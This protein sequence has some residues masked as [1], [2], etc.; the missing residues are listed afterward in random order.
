MIL[1]T[2]AGDRETFSFD[3][4]PIP[5]HSLMHG[6]IS[7]SGRAVDGSSAAGLPAF[8]RAV[9]L[10]S[11][12]I[13]MLPLRTYQGEG[14]EKVETPAGVLRRPNDEMSAFAVWEYA[15]AS[16]VLSGNFFAMKV[17]V[18]GQ[19]KALYPLD[20]R[21]VA[22]KVDGGRI[23]FKVRKGKDT[24][25]YTRDD[26]LFIPGILLDSPVVGV[27]I[28]DNFRHSLGTYLDRQEFESRYLKNDAAVGVVLKHAGNVLPE[29]REEIRA[30]FESR[31][32]GQGSAG[33]PAVLWGGWE[34]ERLPISARDAQFVESSAMSVREVARMTGV[35]AGLLDDPDAP[36]GIA[37]EHE[38]MRFQTYGVGPWQTR[39]EQGLAADPDMLPSGTC[40]EFDNRELLRADLKTRMEA[41]HSARQ[42]GIATANELRPDFGLSPDHPDG[43]VLLATPV[44]GAPN[45][46]AG[47]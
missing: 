7:Y 35:P 17:K 5:P 46:P 20:P 40:A 43:D 29:Q 18:R 11:E 25:T 39:I 33:R 13:A 6:G 9:R 47:E 45:T 21:N 26:V 23:A 42:A 8:L 22:V 19:V 34:M 27:S 10:L 16:M 31:H 15:V 30:G 32:A 24:V 14:A 4:P 28:V 36:G 1:A 38:N 3:M 44:G 37:P 2:P 12:T 41:A